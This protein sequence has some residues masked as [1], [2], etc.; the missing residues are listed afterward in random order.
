MA[1]TDRSVLTVYNIVA[2]VWETLPSLTWTDGVTRTLNLRS[3]VNEP[4]AST[5]FTVHSDTSLPSGWT[6]T[7]AGV[8]TYTPIL[9]QTVQ[10]KFIA[11]RSNLTATS[12]L[13]TITRTQAFVSQLVPDRI[14]IGLAFNSSA[15][16]VYVMNTTDT[17]VTPVQDFINV[18][19]IDGTE[20]LSA[21]VETT[22]HIP[23]GRSGIAFDG[24]YFWLCGHM[25]EG[26]GQLR[27]LNADGTLNSYINYSGGEIESLTWDGT[28]L[29]GLDILQYKL[30]KFTSTAEVTADA[31]DLPRAEEVDDRTGF[32]FQ[33][34]Q[35]G[36][37]YADS[38]FY[39]PQAHIR[40]SHVIFCITPAGARVESRDIEAP[41]AVSG[42]TY[43]PSRDTLWYIVD[44]DNP[45]RGILYATRI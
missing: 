34:A 9:G 41:H 36:L 22:L 10:L 35:W 33:P 28:H 42:V 3:Y 29:W 44:R 6:L 21:T 24:T 20:D 23:T 45:R 19:N 32:D 39:I 14:N 17:G 5:T 1:K 25:N 12:G 2:I 8:L 40:A 4:R 37:C 27:K 43:N 11:H 26:G 18:F 31:V 16:K 30:R 38:H 15:N 7:S 13:L